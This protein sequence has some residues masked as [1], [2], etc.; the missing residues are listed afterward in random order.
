[1]WFRRRDMGFDPV[2]EVNHVRELIQRVEIARSEAVAH[3][4]VVLIA[5]HDEK[6]EELHKLL[7]LL[8]P[9]QREPEK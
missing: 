6:L 1:M 5:I 7:N 9:A 3:G 8:I 4:S 2:A